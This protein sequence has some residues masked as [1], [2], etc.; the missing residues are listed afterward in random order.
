MSINGILNTA[1]NSLLTYQLAIDLA[2]SNIA[3][4]NTPGYSRQRPVIQSV[5]SVDLGSNRAQVDV[6]VAKIERIYDEYLENQV[7][8]QAQALGYGEAKSDFMGRIEGIVGEGTGG[9]SDLLNKFWN[10]WG[11]LSAN[12]QGQAAR[13][14]LLAAAENLTS[15]FRRIDSDLTQV[16]GDAGDQINGMVAEINNYLSE[17]ADLNSKITSYANDRGEANIHKDNR[18]ELLK[19]LSGLLDINYLEDGIG[20][21]NVFLADGRSLISNDKVRPLAVEM[22][23]ANAVSDIVYADNTSESLKSAIVKGKG[24]KLAALLELGDTIVP[25]YREKLDAFAATLTSEVNAIHRLGYDA[26]GNAGGDFFVPATDAGSFSV[27]D[28][29]VSDINKIAISATLNGDGENARIIGAIRD[30]L[31]MSGGSA[32]LNDYYSSLVGQIGRDVA[33]AKSNMEYRTSVMKQLTDRRESVSGVSLDEEMMELIKYQ[34]A[35]N[36][37]GKLVSTVNEMLTTLMQLGR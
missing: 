23:G 33:D 12:P 36:A 6:N 11:E 5:Y 9:P 24:G 32:T 34:M 20:A 37:A 19:K 16:V 26:Y 28:A 22:N 1:T 25:G 8:K 15:T 21:I 35:Y 13:N 27:S 31:V 14:S 29:V 3:N 17:I 7:V 10:A 18:M 2:G 30:E 4:V